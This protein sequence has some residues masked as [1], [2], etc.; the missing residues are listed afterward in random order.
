MEGESSIESTL[1][2]ELFQKFIGTEMED[3]IQGTAKKIT[4][5]IHES[6]LERRYPAFQEPSFEGLVIEIQFPKA[7]KGKTIVLKDEGRVGNF[8]TNENS[9]DLTVVHLEDPQFESIFQVYSNNQIEAR[10]LLTT[11]FM[12]RLIHL[13]EALS[14]ETIQ[15]EFRDKS[16]ILAINSHKDLFEPRGLSQTALQ[17]EDIHQFLAQMDSIFKLIDVLK[18]SAR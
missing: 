11:A 12:E 7:F 16:L 1:Q 9:K 5:K 6:I 3:F 14:S 13:K 18:I 4:F 2:G 10:F 15:C 17:V 8:L